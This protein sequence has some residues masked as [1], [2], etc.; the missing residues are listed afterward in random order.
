MSKSAALGIICLV[1]FG[2]GLWQFKPHG[3]TSIV[4]HFWRKVWS[5][6]IPH[7][8]RHF[9]WRTCRDIIPTKVN[10]MRWNVLQDCICDES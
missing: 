7:K 10:L 8:I 2:L 3:P 5:L 4:P 1:E 9:A 6:P